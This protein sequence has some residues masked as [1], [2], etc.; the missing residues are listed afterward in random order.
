MIISGAILQRHNDKD[1]AIVVNSDG[2]PSGIPI[3][4]ANRHYQE[5]LDAIIAEGSD[6]FANEISDELQAA[7]DAKKFN[8]QLE[9]Y[10]TAV[11]RLAQYQLSVGRDEKKEMRPTGEKVYNEVEGTYD[12]VMMN[13]VVQSAIEPLPAKITKTTYDPA[14]FKTTTSEVDNPLI[15][16]DDAERKAAQDVVDATPTKVKEAA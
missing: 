10:K 6:C 9:D 5:V 15:V 14:K 4:P 13:V 11:A 2:V 16:Q 7:A 12:D 3:D 8:Q 1:I